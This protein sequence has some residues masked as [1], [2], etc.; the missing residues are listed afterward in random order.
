MGKHVHVTEEVDETNGRVRCRKCGWVAGTRKRGILRCSVAV[1]EQRGVGGWGNVTNGR[2]RTSQGY[3]ALKID[4]VR[5]LEHRWVMEKKLGRPLLP[6]EN[7]HHI[8][9]VR[10]DNREENLELWSTWQPPGQ[11]VADKVAWAREVLDLYG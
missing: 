1:N 11:R 9:G 5:I 7:V 10:D 6:H 3:I 4:G 2:M 8:N